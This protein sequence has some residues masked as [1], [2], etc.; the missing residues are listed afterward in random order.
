MRSLLAIALAL[1][2]ASHVAAETVPSATLK[3]IAEVGVGLGYACARTEA[4]LV[5]CWGESKQ[6]HLGREQQAHFP[7]EIPLPAPARRLWVRGDFPVCAE[8]ARDGSLW[9]WG[10]DQPTPVVQPGLEQSPGIVELRRSIVMRCAL[11]RDGSVRCAGHRPEG[12]RYLRFAGT[13][14]A[15]SSSPFESIAELSNVVQLGLEN[16]LACVR[17]RA[18][19]V[20]CWGRNDLGQL[21]TGGSR[22]ATGTPVVPRGLDRGVQDLMV[23]GDAACVI[24]TGG[25]VRCWGEA[26]METHASFGRTPTALRMPAPARSLHGWINGGLALLQDGTLATW[27]WT[28]LGDGKSRQVRRP[29]RVEGI[30][31]STQVAGSGP[32]YASTAAGWVCWGDCV[33]TWDPSPIAPVGLS[34]EASAPVRGPA[35]GLTCAVRAGEVLCRG[36][37]DRGQLGDGSTVERRT[38]WRPVLAPRPRTP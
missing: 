35:D 4:G 30:A 24:V 16:E 3:G 21:G 7:I 15:P 22:H 23:L 31:A 11:L 32:H 36:P 29:T 26:D 6:G 9:C 8:L 25:A 1:C 13:E 10:H 19:M 18:G 28:A 37:N 17:T 27:G 38:E 34:A 33:S 12:D 20:R 2:A 14:V 5:L